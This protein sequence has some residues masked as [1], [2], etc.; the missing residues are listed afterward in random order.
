[1]QNSDS[2]LWPLSR[3]RINKNFFRSFSRFGKINT[4]YMNVKS[5][6]TLSVRIRFC[7]YLLKMWTWHIKNDIRNR[8]FVLLP[9]E[10]QFYSM[11]IICCTHAWNFSKNV[12]LLKTAMVLGMSRTL[13]PLGH[14]GFWTQ[15][16]CIH[17]AK[18][19][20]RDILYSQIKIVL[21]VVFYHQFIH[22][23]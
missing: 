15:K 16:I 20:N 21:S 1:M 10:Q 9:N 19:I 7:G 5:L 11:K 18:L 12:F 14:V 17:D 8:S 6:S 13:W 3:N 22:S 2:H 23:K 4:F